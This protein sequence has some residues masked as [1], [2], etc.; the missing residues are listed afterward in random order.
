MGD[1]IIFKNFENHNKICYPHVNQKL[2]NSYTCNPYIYNVEM[3]FGCGKMLRLGDSID[4][5]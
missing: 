2:S 5:P 1:Q 4:V 3:G